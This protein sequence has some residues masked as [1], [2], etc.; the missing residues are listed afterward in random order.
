MQA[1][2]FKLFD[3]DFFKGEKGENLRTT[4]YDQVFKEFRNLKDL[5]H[6]K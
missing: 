5:K 3:L 1:K 2:T 4:I 6:F